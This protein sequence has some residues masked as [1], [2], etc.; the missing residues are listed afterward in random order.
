MGHSRGGSRGKD[1]AGAVVN[2]EHGRNFCFVDPE[3]KQ[4]MKRYSKRMSYGA[5]EG[6]SVS[7]VDKMT[8]VATEYKNKYKNLNIVFNVS[9]PIK[10]KLHFSVLKFPA[11][12]L[13]SFSG[14]N[15]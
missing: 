2:R 15:L 12:L 11:P 13:K 9:C 10:R 14:T 7:F 5:E 3:G 8:F 6:D 1:T 4:V